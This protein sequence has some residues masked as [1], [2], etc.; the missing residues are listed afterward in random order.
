VTDDID[1]ASFWRLPLSTGSEQRIGCV[2]PM[3][4]LHIASGS[5]H[6]LAFARSSM[7]EGAD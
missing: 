5:R 3:A 1:V 4:E 2:G 6:C 7:G